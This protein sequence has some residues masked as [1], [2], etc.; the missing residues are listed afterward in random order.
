M[1]KGDIVLIKASRGEPGVRRI[2]DGAPERP[3]VCL[4]EYWTR[5]ERNQVDPICV[6]IGRDQV[7]QYDAAIATALEQAYAAKSAGDA[8]AGTRLDK[9]WAQVKP[10]A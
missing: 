6:Q 10:A 9:L 5:W 2:W 7:F 8:Q 4:E 1:K 3:F